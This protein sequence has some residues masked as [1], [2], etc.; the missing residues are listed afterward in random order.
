M[1][2]DAMAAGAVTFLEKPFRIQTLCDH[3][4][5]AIRLDAGNRTKRE[6]G[7]ELQN[8]LS[9]LTNKEREVV[10]LLIGGNTNK[11]IASKLGLSRRGIEDRRARIMKKLNL[12]TV[13]ELHELV[14]AVRSS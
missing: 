6:S 2:V 7:V 5:R 14:T 1:A 8:R 12:K 10:E 13:A 11:V 4:Q 9:S 3:I